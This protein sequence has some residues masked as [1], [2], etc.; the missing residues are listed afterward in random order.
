MTLVLSGKSTSLRTLTEIA[1]KQVKRAL[2][3]VDG[4]GDVS[5][6]GGPPARNSHRRRH[7]EAERPRPVDRPGARRHQKENVEIPGGTLEQGKWEV[8]LRTLG[9][10]DATRSSTTSSS[11]RS[12]GTPCGCTTSATPEDSTQ[13]VLTSLFTADGSPACSSTSGARPARTRSRVTEAVKAKLTSSRRRC[14]AA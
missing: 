11:R 13:R 14:R 4:V 8:G 7:R 1:D 9:R 2:E 3:S 10:V 5:M 12:N 6:S